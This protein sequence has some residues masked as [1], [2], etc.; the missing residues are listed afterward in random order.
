[1]SDRNII[2][3]IGTEIGSH[4]LT[5]EEDRERLAAAQVLAG[6]ESLVSRW[7]PLCP[8][9]RVLLLGGG[10][11]AFADFHEAVR[12]A[13]QDGERVVVLADG[14]PLYYGIGAS[15]ARILPPESLL[16]LPGHSCLQ[17][18]WARLGLPWSGA[19]SASLHGRD[20]WRELAT[21]LAGGQPVCILGDA[22]HGAP[23]VAAWLLERGLQGSLHRFAGLNTPREIH[24]VYSLEEAAART[25]QEAMPLLLFMPD[26]ACRPAARLNPSGLIA[27]GALITK[28]AVRAAVVALMRIRSDA[29]VW[30]IGSGSGSIAFAAADLAW[31]GWVCAVEGQAKRSAMIR[32]N[33]RLL[34]AVNVDV[35][36]ARAPEGMEALPDPDCVNV[37]GGLGDTADAASALLKA[38]AA[39]LRPGGRVTAPCVLM[40]S[41]TLFL[42]FA[43]A[44]GWACGATLIQASELAPLGGGERFE[45]QNPVFAAWA[46]KPLTSS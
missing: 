37:G 11:L 45:A 3:V 23:Q 28:P 9:A 10:G 32:E 41:V 35:L 19:R 42:D 15:L 12:Q 6:G 16:L 34:Q 26:A 7:K 22:A 44:R 21:A 5:R 13:W 38:V 39:R 31:N 40:G 24:D 29:V 27:D 8:Q 4:D 14:D 18:A 46:E 33:R 20:G 2:A 43:R 25:E 1:M 30:D 17:T 36:T